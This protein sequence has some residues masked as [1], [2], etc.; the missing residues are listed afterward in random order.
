[1]RFGEPNACSTSKVGVS[2]K[3]VTHIWRVSVKDVTHIWLT[4]THI[5]QVIDEFKLLARLEK[6]R[7]HLWMAT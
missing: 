5:C 4:K 6:S 7:L 2:A 3:S 1:M